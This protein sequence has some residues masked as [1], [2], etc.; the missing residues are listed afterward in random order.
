MS[1]GSLAYATVPVTATVAPSPCPH[2]RMNLVERFCV[3]LTE[4]HVWDGSLASVQDLKDSI[5]GHFEKCNH[6]TGTVQTGS[7]H[8]EPRSLLQR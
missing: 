1:T 3:D 7:S 4:D 6:Y 2:S 8:G 5:A